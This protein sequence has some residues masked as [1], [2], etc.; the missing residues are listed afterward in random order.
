MYF[1]FGCVILA[2]EARRL[3]KGPQLRLVLSRGQ[4]PRLAGISYQQL[5][6]EKYYNR[7]FYVYV[8]AYLLIYVIAVFSVQ[9]GSEL[10]ALAGQQ[11][12]Q[13]FRG[14]LG[15][16]PLSQMAMRGRWSLL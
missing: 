11:T 16:A 14:L 9:I 2:V 5:S 13:D 15:R 3:F 8:S 7:G 12:K 6:N 1:T 4:F 10:R